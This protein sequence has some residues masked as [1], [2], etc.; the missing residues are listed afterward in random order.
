[1]QQCKGGRMVTVEVELTD[2]Q[3]RSLN[4]IADE[5]G[6]PVAEIIQKSIDLYVQEQGMI[7]TPEQRRRAL[8]VVGKYRSGLSDVIAKHDDY[9]ADIYEEVDE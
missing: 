4:K 1:M 3:T 7:G 8:A 9:L 5:Q 6:I 2:E